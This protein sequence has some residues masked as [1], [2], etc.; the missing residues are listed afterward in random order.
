MTSDNSD[1]FQLLHGFEQNTWASFDYLSRKLSLNT[2][3]LLQIERICNEFN[4]KNVTQMSSPTLD[5]ITL[6]NLQMLN[7]KCDKIESNLQQL[8]MNIKS[9][10]IDSDSNDQLTQQLREQY[11]KLID[12]SPEGR[13]TVQQHQTPNF[14]RNV[15]VTSTSNEIDFDNINN[16]LN[17][18]LSTDADHNQ[19]SS[20]DENVV[21]RDETILDNSIVGD[22]TMMNVHLLGVNVM[23]TVLK[24]NFHISPF[25]S[26]VSPKCL[27]DFIAA[28]AEI[29]RKRIKII[30]LTK[31]G[32]DISTLSHVNFKIET[33]EKIAEIVN[34]SN[35]WP[36][37]I[38]IKPWVFKGAV[39][40]NSFLC[41]KPT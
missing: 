34:Q 14:E 8:D 13:S 1:L 37:H 10:H 36:S 24:K 26:K 17:N 11:L 39:N 20:N 12:V 29:D 31:R 19:S 16:R 22:S 33:D 28:N 6:D 41:N 3:T 40:A 35:F 18:L 2:D 27:V 25:D 9:L 23:S 15:S 30:R 21:N 4:V 7:D 38:K 5:S 32:Q